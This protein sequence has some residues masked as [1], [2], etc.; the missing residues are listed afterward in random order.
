MHIAIQQEFTKIYRGKCPTL[1]Y[2]CIV[3]LKQCFVVFDIPEVKD[4][5]KF[6]ALPMLKT[7]IFRNGNTRNSFGSC[8]D[9]RK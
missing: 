7:A 2:P 3:K 1:Y 6:L 8:L 5:S 4:L 9:P